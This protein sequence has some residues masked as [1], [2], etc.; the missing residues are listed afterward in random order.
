PFDIQGGG[1]DLIYPHHSMCDE[2]TKITKN[3]DFAEI[4]CHVGMVS[5][6]G[7]KMS[8]SKGNLVFVHQLID[9]GINPLVIR[10][11]LISKPWH[12][13]WEFIFAEIEHYRNT[14]NNLKKCAQKYIKLNDFENIL[15]FILNNLDFSSAIEY[16]LNVEKFDEKNDL[17]ILETDSK[18][19]PLE[20]SKNIPWSG[21]WVMA[22]G[23]ADGYEGSV[24][25][26]NILN[27]ASKDILITNNISQ[28][29]SGGAMIDNE[30]KVIGVVTWGMNYRE[31]QYN[32]GGILDRYCAKILKCEYEYKGKKTWFDYSE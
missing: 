19:K 13:D 24:A 14:F 26:G 17:A 22:L 7:S 12:Q 6:E 23:S 29:N 32:G 3:K 9:Q 11:L 4:Y 21:Y 20:L 27:V 30:G 5:Y 1:N 16:V 31:S 10:L 8:K 15:K 2:I 28:G 25:F 18:L